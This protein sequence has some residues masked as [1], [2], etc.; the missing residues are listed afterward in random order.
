MKTFFLDTE[1]TGLHPPNDKLVE[2]AIL[3]ATGEVVLDT[4][5][6][7]LRPIG[8]ATSIHGITDE[9][10]VDAP[11]LEDLWPVISGIIRDNHVVIYNAQFDTRFFPGHLDC[12]A[13]VSCAMVRFAPIYGQWHP[14]YQDY[15][16]QKLTTAAHF[17]GYT[18]VGDAHRALADTRATR[19]LWNW[20]DA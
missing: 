2:I 18:W 19:A 9:M 6:N 1:T 13:Q 10:V 12:A 3:D 11:T 8:F 16:W 14:V 20:M 4:L 17:I 5:V 15:T 7:P